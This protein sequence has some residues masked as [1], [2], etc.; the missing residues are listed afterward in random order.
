MF[1][2]NKQSKTYIKKVPAA[3]RPPAFT[4]MTALAWSGVRNGP[5]WRCFVGAHTN[6]SVVL[7]T[8]PKRPDEVLYTN[9]LKFND[10]I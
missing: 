9:T 5:G 8:P 1:S 7:E 6:G 3:S 4:D 10:R 2:H